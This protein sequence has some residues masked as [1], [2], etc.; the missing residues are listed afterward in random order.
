MR[1][2]NWKHQIRDNAGFTLYEAVVVLAITGI[3]IT[4]AYGI[5][6]I[7]AQTMNRVYTETNLRWDA[8]KAMAALRNDLQEIDPE[9]I[10]NFKSHKLFFRTQAGVQ[11]KYLANGGRLRRKEGPGPWSV[12]TTFLQ[13]NPFTYYDSTLSTTNV[14][15]E[16]C[17]INVRLNVQNDRIVVNMS[18]RFYVRN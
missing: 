12:Y 9:N 7:Q 16:V 1:E 18:D 3:V 11:I 15:A 10:M 6:G 2:W 14:K 5:M 13:N 17:Y 4:L 8:R